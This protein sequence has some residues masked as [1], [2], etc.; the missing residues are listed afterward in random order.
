MVTTVTKLSRLLLGRK[1]M[2]NLESILKIRDITLLTQIHTVKA[3]VFPAGK[4]GCESWTI[5]KA[6]CWRI[7]V[8][9][10]WCW[11]RLLSPL[12][13]KEIK[14]VNPKGI[15]SWI[16]FGRTDA[17]AE[18]SIL[19]PPDGKSWLIGKVSDTVKDWEQKEKRASE[20]EMAGWHHRLD[21]R[22]SEW[23]PGIGD[24]QGGLACCGLSGH[25]GSDMT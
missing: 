7:Y 20:D 19:W 15:Q 24:G 21:G 18:A 5:K 4:D 23:T 1:A 10:L 14:P 6:E 3:M 22:E 9:E 16:F 8:F 13:C 12:D 17:E 11:T 2:T 25:K